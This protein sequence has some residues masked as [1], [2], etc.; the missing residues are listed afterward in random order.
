M[1]LSQ[2][3]EY[4]E[5]KIHN[6]RL[7]LGSYSE[8]VHRIYNESQL[9]NN[10][11]IIT[12]NIGHLH[13]LRTKDR[14]RSALNQAFL[15]LPDGWPIAMLA[16][17]TTRTWQSR[18][19]GSDLILKLLFMDKETC[20][21]VAVLGLP[22]SYHEKLKAVLKESARNVEL[23]YLND[24]NPSVF[25][26]GDALTKIA[27]EI[28]ILK[29]NLIISSFGSPKQELFNHEILVKGSFGIAIGGGASIDFLVGKQKRSPRFFRIIGLEWLYRIV[30]EPRRLIFRYIVGLCELNI[31]IARHLFSKL[32]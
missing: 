13:S 1:T 30:R 25:L 16:S 26:S 11:L 21:K 31:L 8:I 19:T 18:I 6:L 27:Q 29:P 23:V 20:W 14:Y 9:F 15:S 24:M 10:R 28:N 17:L 3:K 4:K 2:P 12:P 22:T 7:T 32:G 5:V